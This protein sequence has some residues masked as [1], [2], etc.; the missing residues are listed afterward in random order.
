MKPICPFTPTSNLIIERSQITLDLV[1]KDVKKVVFKKMGKSIESGQVQCLTFTFSV[2]SKV[3]IYENLKN[4]LQEAMGKQSISNQTRHAESDAVENQS[5]VPLNL[6]SKNVKNA[7]FESMTSHKNE[8]GVTS[9]TFIFTTLST[10]PIYEEVDS[11]RE[12][13]GSE[14]NNPP[15]IPWATHPARWG[16]P[17]PPYELVTKRKNP[18]EKIMGFF[19]KCFPKRSFPVPQARDTSYAFDSGCECGVGLNKALTIEKEHIYE[20]PR[21]F[22]PVIYLKVLP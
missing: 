1:S 7:F 4:V 5:K 12:S 2:L 22:E 18:L 21:Q 6:S 14:K 11:Q 9:L 3:H 8:S 20:I 16:I 15:P 19:H 13:K 17:H 10:D